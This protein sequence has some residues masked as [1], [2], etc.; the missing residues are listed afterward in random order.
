MSE[1]RIDNNYVYHYFVTVRAFNVK[2]QVLFRDI[3]EAKHWLCREG[4]VIR[5][6]AYEIDSTHLQLHWH[7][8]LTSTKPVSYKDNSRFLTMR[9]Y[10][11]QLKT[12]SAVN[13]VIIYMLKQAQDKIARSR[14]RDFLHYRYNYSF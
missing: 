8:W 2:D 11:K 10:W 13:K 5:G 14:M 9:V 6:E 7:G 3:K 4:L 1:A 12:L